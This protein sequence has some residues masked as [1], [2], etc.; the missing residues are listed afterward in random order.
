MLQPTT[1]AALQFVS[2]D[3]DDAASLEAAIRGADLVLHTAGPFQRKPTCGV[4]EAAIAAGV[5]YMD[6]CDDADYS[7]RAKQYHQQ[8]Q[9]AGI[10]AITTAGASPTQAPM[11]VLF[12]WQVAVLHDSV[13]VWILHQK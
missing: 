1:F 12:C 10:P 7:Q 8:A 4:L 5:P 3:I 13:M 11:K 6:V 9:A 2:V